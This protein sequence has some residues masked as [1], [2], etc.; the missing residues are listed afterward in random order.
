MN[1]IE[2]AIQ[3]VR[4]DLWTV[5][6]HA[7]PFLQRSLVQTLRLAIAVGLEFRHRLLEPVLAPPV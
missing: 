1:H 3:F 4:Q 5:E 2:R 6:I 7:L